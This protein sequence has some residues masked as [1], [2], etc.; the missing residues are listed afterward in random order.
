[1]HDPTPSTEDQASPP[2]APAG[3]SKARFIEAAALE[4]VDA[5]YERCTIRAIAA[6]AGTSIASLSRNWSGKRHL[7]EDVFGLHFAAI[8]AAQNRN[9]DLLEQAGSPG[10]DEL[11]YAFY[12][13]VLAPFPATGEAS[14]ATPSHQVYCKA[15]ADP[16]D[17]AKAIVRPLVAPVRAR[18][19]GYARQFLPQGSEHD[20]YLAMTLVNGA[21]IYPQVHGARLAAVLGLDEKSIDWDKAAR[22]LGRMVAAGILSFRQD[23]P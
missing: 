8:E 12:R 17:E 15:L 4:F 5:G 18:M 21:Y 14:P 7:F 9:L 6:R 11:L 13:P 1:M 19:I 23:R 20:L 22:G 2:L 3:S 16:A 10:L